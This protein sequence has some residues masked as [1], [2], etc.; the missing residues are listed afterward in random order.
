MAIVGWLVVMEC[1]IVVVEMVVCLVVEVLVLVVGG[2]F[3][4]GND[5]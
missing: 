5:I 1:K 3:R 2:S 4:N